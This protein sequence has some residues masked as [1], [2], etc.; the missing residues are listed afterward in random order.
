MGKI[1]NDNSD[2]GMA[3]LWIFKNY[4]FLHNTEKLSHFPHS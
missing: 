2:E 1:N 4:Y 3:F